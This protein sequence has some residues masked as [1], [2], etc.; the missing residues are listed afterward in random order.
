MR[1]PKRRIIKGIIL[2]LAFIAFYLGVIAPA[3][4]QITEASMGVH[5]RVMNR[6]TMTVN[7]DDGET[8]VSCSRPV[9]YRVSISQPVSSSTATVANRVTVNY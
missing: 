8:S 9:A 5:L 4:A 1:Y 2:E 6:C 3:M 7:S